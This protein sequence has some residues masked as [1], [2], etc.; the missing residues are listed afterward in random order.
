MVLSCFCFLKIIFWLKYLCSWHTYLL[1]FFMLFGKCQDF[2]YLRT[3][4]KKCWYLSDFLTNITTGKKKKICTSAIPHKS[5]ETH[6]WGK[7]S[8]MQIFLVKITVKI[9]SKV[10]TLNNATRQFWKL[11]IILNYLQNSQF[12]TLNAVFEAV[13]WMFILPS[14]S[15]AKSYPLIL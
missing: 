10:Q 14:T 8:G 5:R 6:D 13:R 15:T 1:F 3:P 11:K 9:V 12:C 7:L 2:T 4:I